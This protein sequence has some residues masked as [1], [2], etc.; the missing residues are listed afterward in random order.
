MTQA[1]H[2]VSSSMMERE[3]TTERECTM[4][5]EC[6]ILERGT[7]IYHDLD[8]HLDHENAE[9]HERENSAEEHHLIEREREREEER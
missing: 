2:T 3:C 7:G 4:E 6:M 1:L 8:A 5:R 9:R